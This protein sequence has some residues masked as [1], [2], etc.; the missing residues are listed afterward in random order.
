MLLN[1]AVE[2]TLSALIVVVLLAANSSV[3]LG[4]HR[5]P[6]VNRPANDLSPGQTI[7]LAVAYQAPHRS[8]RA[9]SVRACS[10]RSC[11]LSWLNCDIDMGAGADGACKLGAGGCGE[12]PVR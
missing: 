3:A 9:F 8:R 12:G 4:E 11:C 10:S 7:K 5:L 2:C 1:R 6:H